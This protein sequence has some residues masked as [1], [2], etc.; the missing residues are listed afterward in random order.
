MWAVRNPSEAQAHALENM[1]GVIDAFGAKYLLD[2]N[3][4]PMMY[5]D[6]EPESGKPYHVMDRKYY[7]YWSAA[8]VAGLKFGGSTIR[9]RPAVYLNL[10]DSSQSWLNLNAAC[11][12]GSV[13]EGVSVAY[14]VHEDGSKDEAAPPPTFDKMVWDDALLTPKPNPIPHGHPNAKIPVLV[15]QYYGDYPKVRLPNGKI[16]GGDIDFEMVNPNYVG[17]V[18]SGLVPPPLQ[19]T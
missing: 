2:R 17:V 3:I 13:C 11:V 8:L 19:P 10:G 14:Y 12:G 1:K 7:E 15:W 18:S 16:K 6:L 4:S 9:F 5:L